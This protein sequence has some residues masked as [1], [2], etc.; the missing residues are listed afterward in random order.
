M[1]QQKPVKNE[2]LSHIKLHLIRL[3]RVKYNEGFCLYDL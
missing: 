3:K 1:Y 2:H